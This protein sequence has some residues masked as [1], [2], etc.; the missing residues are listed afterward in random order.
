[1]EASD[2]F[3]SV[4]DGD[5]RLMIIKPVNKKISKPQ[6]NFITDAQG[7]YQSLYYFS[8]TIFNQ[9]FNSFNVL[10]H[11]YETIDVY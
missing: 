11:I 6:C 4:H 5:W 1:M 10:F 2:C 9:S 8:N 7:L 3:Y